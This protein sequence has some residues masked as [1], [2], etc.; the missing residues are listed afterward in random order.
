MSNYVSINIAEIDPTGAVFHNE[1][2][3]LPYYI[4]KDEKRPVTKYRH[5]L[6]P[7]NKNKNIFN[8]LKNQLEQNRLLND[9]D[10]KK[11][12]RK[13]ILAYE[14]NKLA[15]F[16]IHRQNE[17]E[18]DYKNRYKRALQKSTKL[19]QEA[20]IIFSEEQFLKCS[21]EDIENSITSFCDDFEEKYGCK[22]LYTSLHLDEGHT[23]DVEKIENG[24]I[25]TIPKKVYNTHAH[26]LIENYNFETHKTCL[27]RL[28]YRK[29]QTEIASHFASLGFI[30]GESQ[31]AM[32]VN[33]E[34]SKDKIKH[35]A[36]LDHKQY[37]RVMEQIKPEVSQL[38]NTFEL[39]I[40]PLLNYFK[41][42]DEQTLKLSIENLINLD[43]ENRVISNEVKQFI[44]E[45]DFI[46]TIKKLVGQKNSQ[47]IKI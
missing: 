42:D 11:Q 46:G 32:T 13:N 10:E 3:E 12:S 43:Q 16:F 25:K 9:D 14:N 23:E 38:K 35:T 5:I 39:L 21:K 41:V 2:V 44:S 26:F 17:I 1:R 18:I 15:Q 4:F 20:I 30:R 47:A 19:Y 27:Q 22:I 37:R 28:D 8:K 31:Y 33:G 29:L 34:F 36:R 40:E 7:L 24:E 45:P 6:E